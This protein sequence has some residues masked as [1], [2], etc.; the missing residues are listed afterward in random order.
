M[1]YEVVGTVNPLVYGLKLYW[2]EKVNGK[3][4]LE[5]WNIFQKWLTKNNCVPGNAVSIKPTSLVVQVIV[6]RK[7]G[8]EQNESP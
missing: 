2:P 6:K 4:A 7:M 1:V 8:N 5:I 3:V